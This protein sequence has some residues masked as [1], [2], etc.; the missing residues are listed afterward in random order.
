MNQLKQATILS[1]AR[2]AMILAVAT[3]AGA[4][5][6]LHLLG[7][8]SLWID[9]AASVRF[10]TMS[11]GLFLHTLW[12]YQGNM[13]L[14]YFLL[15]AWLH[16]GDSEV[17]VRSLSVLFGVLTLPAIYFLGARLFDRATGLTAATLL[18]VHSFHIF[19]SRQ[20]RAYSLLTLLLVLTAYFLICAMESSGK[21]QNWYWAAFAI[22]AALCVYAHIFAV[23]V[24]AAYALAIAFPKPFRVR[25]WTI[26]LIVILFEH[27]I[28]P[29][30]LFVLLHH[31]DQINWIAPPTWADISEYLAL[32]TS[33]GGVLL[34][35]VYV[36]LCALAFLSPAEGKRPDK[37][38]WALRL[39]VFWLV[40]PPL[41]TL[42]VS[43]IKPLFNPPFMVMC[44]PALVLL[45]GRGLTNLYSATTV[46]RWAGASAFV[47]VI[48]L[49][50][51]SVESPPRYRMAMN[52]DWRSAVRYILERE[53]V[54]DGAVFY[55]PND[56]PYIY[57]AHRAESQH[58][59]TMAPDVLYPPDPWEP[60]SRE[61]IMHVTSGRKR[62]WLILH[63][64]SFNPKDS[65]VIQSTLTDTSFR[66]LEKH[67]FAG[68]PSI[69][70]ALY[71]R[72]Q[73]DAPTT[74]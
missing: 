65:A 35:M 67:V 50:L 60:L 70:V 59:A 11:W 15:R 19:W 48:A 42:A 51:V 6:R 14:Y 21:R 22:T 38:G 40:L 3:L 55:V 24:L 16:L 54:G 33:Q 20:A 64:E 43:P 2:T 34:M 25:A 36:A 62:V 27:L 26:I 9:E 4:G 12:G 47:L 46:K 32:M 37:E 23:L 13:T 41:L 56:Y 72:A 1:P 5:L 58:W 8:E 57:Y 63:N 7:R 53:Q 71:G 28:A 29:M 66:S 30:A 52:A 31:S 39:L 74:R 68:D 61:E 45:A 69:T 73:Q 18:S 10:A 44:L 17:L 49:S